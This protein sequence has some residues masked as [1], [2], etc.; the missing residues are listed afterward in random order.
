M[1]KRALVVVALAA[2]LAAGACATGSIAVEDAGGNDATSN[3]VITTGD[4]TKDGEAGCAPPTIKCAG[5]A[6]SCVDITK[7]PNNCG[8]CGTVCTGADAGPE[9]GNGNPD[10]G[11]PIPDGGLDGGTGWTF[12]SGSCTNKQ[13]Q[14]DC[15]DSG[16]Q[17][18]SDKLCWD[19]QSS[20]EHCGSCN[21][22][23]ATDVEWCTHAHCC[24]TGTDYCGSQCVST[25]TDNTNC[26]VCGNVCPSNAPA[27]VNGK[28]SAQVSITTVCSKSNPTGIFCS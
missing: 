17:L 4:A 14:L 16:A 19:M 10:A 8:Q 11:I 5:D 15:G 9:G 13:C 27:C 25:N 1:G 26:G 23:C 24:A 22:A 2:T 28:C 3:D 20:H 6:Q 12:P 7:D 21:T 18:C